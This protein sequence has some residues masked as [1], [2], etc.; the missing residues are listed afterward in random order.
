M[1]TLTTCSSVDT[2]DASADRGTSRSRPG[3]PRHARWGA[4]CR[5]RRYPRKGW[6]VGSGKTPGQGFARDPS[7]SPRGARS[8]PVVCTGIRL[9]V[10]LPAKWHDED[11]TRGHFASLSDQVAAPREPF[12]DTN[13]PAC[14]ASVRSCFALLWDV[15]RASAALLVDS[16]RPPSSLRR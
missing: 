6:K 4:T 16:H 12:P 7:R 2:C 9:R 1:A 11:N 10:P 14:S 3:N 13:R 15:P 8:P 5:S